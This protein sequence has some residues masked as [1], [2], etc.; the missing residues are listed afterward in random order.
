MGL[1]VILFYVGF[2]VFHLIHNSSRN[3]HRAFTGIAN[4]FSQSF[5]DACADFRRVKYKL[6]IKKISVTQ[7]NTQRQ[8]ARNKWRL[9]LATSA[10]N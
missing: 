2:S 5:A 9:M 6:E 8:S 7:R 3:R 1:G 4:G 10:I